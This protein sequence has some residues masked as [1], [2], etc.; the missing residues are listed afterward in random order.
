MRNRICAEHDLHVSDVLSAVKLYANY[1]DFAKML[2]NALYM[3][4]NNT[5]IL[6]YSY[7]YI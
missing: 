5:L 4:C 2:R 6:L 1:V 7:F 3:K